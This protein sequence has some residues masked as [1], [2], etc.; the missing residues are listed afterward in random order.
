VIP[1]TKEKLQD[2]LN[3]LQIKMDDV[4]MV[5]ENNAKFLDALGSINLATIIAKKKVDID[6]D[7]MIQAKLIEDRTIN[8]LVKNKKFQS[9][10]NQ[11]EFKKYVLE[12]DSILKD[13]KKYFGIAKYIDWDRSKKNELTFPS[14]MV[15]LFYLACGSWQVGIDRVMDTI[16]EIEQ[17]N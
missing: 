10:D 3:F 16:I 13:V 17:N 1:S 4:K 5:S 6:I 12:Q 14:K 8:E 11:N 7:Q 15:E 2:V 9:L